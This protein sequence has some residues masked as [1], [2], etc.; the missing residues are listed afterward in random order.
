[1][2]YRAFLG[3]EED[4]VLPYLGGPSVAASGRTL[5]VEGSLDRGWWR[6]RVKGRVARAVGRAEAPEDV[7]AARPAVR[8]HLCGTWLATDD[9]RTAVV[10]LRPDDEPPRFAACRARRWH[11][12]ELLFEQ[13]E[14]E[15]EAE[16]AVR[17]AFEDGRALVDVKGVPASLRAAFGYAVAEVAARERAVP[18]APVE[19][20][21]RVLEIA[22]GGPEVARREVRR[23]EAERE[24][25]AEEAAR[26]ERA[27]AAP[28]PTATWAPSGQAVAPRPEDGAERARDALRAAGAEMLDC[29]SRG[30]GL[31]EVTYRLEGE[32]FVS[33]VNA[34][35]LQVI[36]AGIC[37][38]GAD[39][40]VTL[41]S[42][43]SVIREGIELGVLVITRRA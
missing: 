10:H 27:H 26:R 4:L 2:D 37:L 40:L 1:M 16:D 7:M 35:T 29:R 11:D 33:V 9:A 14:L 31:I 18:V 3:R 5:R 6:F 21:A 32:R 43:P 39:R 25:F 41:D 24:R 13:L 23:I 22:E 30:G 8:G 19:I 36:D 42:L 28:A 20:R 34:S 15:S 17:R 38:S 12:G